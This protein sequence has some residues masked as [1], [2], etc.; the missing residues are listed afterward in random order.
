MSLLMQHRSVIRYFVL[1][2]KS[3]Q[4]IAAKL[5]KGYGQDALYLRAVQ[6]WEARFRAGQENLEDDERSGR[7]PQTDIRNVILR[8]LEKNPELFIP[9]Y[10]Q[11][12]VHSKNNNSPPIDRP[13]AEVLSG[14]LDLAPAF[15]AAKGR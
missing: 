5:V 10:Q 8:F 6:K 3:N 11:G 7:P 14:P 13:W 2:Q 1:C 12:S 9:G 15:R 4:Q